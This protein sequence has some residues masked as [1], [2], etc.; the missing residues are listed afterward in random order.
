MKNSYQRNLIK[1][2][3]VI[4]GIIIGYW[5]FRI[6]MKAIFLFS[7]NERIFSWILIFSGPLLTLPSVIISIKKIKISALILLCGSIVSFVMMI[8]TEGYGGEHIQQF[9]VKITMPMLML[10]VAGYFI[11]KLRPFRNECE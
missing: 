8:I 7:E 5:H 3:Y 11:N 6:G 2:I 4:V 10:A 1:Y 9:I